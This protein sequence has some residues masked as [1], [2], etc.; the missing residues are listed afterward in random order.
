[1]KEVLILKRW[2]AFFIEITLV[3][4]FHNLR[5]CVIRKKFF[6]VKDYYILIRII[7]IIYSKKKIMW[8][9]V[10]YAHYNDN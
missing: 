5:Y 4:L 7:C 6:N 10:K 8:G 1:M 2:S 3:I 9:I